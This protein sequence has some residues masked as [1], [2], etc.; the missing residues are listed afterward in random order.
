MSLWQN[1]GGG[2]KAWKCEILHPLSDLQQAALSSGRL[3]RVAAHKVAE[4]SGTWA[5]VTLTKCL[6]VTL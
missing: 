4:D 1:K 3:R 5:A 2:E 6:Q